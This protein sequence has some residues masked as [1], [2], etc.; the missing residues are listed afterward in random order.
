[1]VVKFYL[2]IAIPFGVAAIV[3]SGPAILPN[4]LLALANQLLL[5]ALLVLVVNRQLPFAAPQQSQEKGNTILRSI[6]V[7]GIA[8]ILSIFHYF[9]FSMLPAVILC[10]ALS[11]SALWMVFNSIK[12]TSWAMIRQAD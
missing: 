2:P 6:M 12:E 11:T 1:M 3:I 4:I 9:I 10:T 5:A 8:S 7:L